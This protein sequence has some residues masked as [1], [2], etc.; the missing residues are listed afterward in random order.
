VR[1]PHNPVQVPA[2]GDTFQL[3]LA[4]VLGDQAGARGEILHRGRDEHLRR[5]GESCHRAATERRARVSEGH[6]ARSDRGGI[7]RG[8]KGGSPQPARRRVRA[9]GAGRHPARV[10]A[11]RRPGRRRGSGPR[12]VRPVRGSA[13]V[14]PRPGRLRAVPATH[15]RQPVEEPLPAPSGRARVLGARGSEDRGRQHRSG[16]RHVRHALVGAAPA[17]APPAHGARPPLLRGPPGR[18]DRR[19]PRLPPG[20]GPLARRPWSRG[21]SHDPRGI[22]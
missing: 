15:D 6:G 18:H 17:S 5:T 9:V 13:P 22:T 14:P 4:G 3:V 16:C 2:V 12:G 19:T 8:S 21:T 20:H 10:P 7:G 1:L 11:D